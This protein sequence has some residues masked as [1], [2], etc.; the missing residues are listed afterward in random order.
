MQKDL[1]DL[2]KK[3]HLSDFIDEVKEMI[4]KNGHCLYITTHL[5]VIA[6]PQCNLQQQIAKALQE[7]QTEIL[8]LSL[9]AIGNF[10]PEEIK[11]AFN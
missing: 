11:V 6:S 1:H 2:G 8:N 7:T 5:Q 9:E 3:G 10:Q 4:I